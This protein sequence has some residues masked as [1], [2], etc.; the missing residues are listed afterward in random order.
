MVCVFQLGWSE[1]LANAARGD[2]YIHAYRTCT[3]VH[4]H[5]CREI[6]CVRE[7]ENVFE[8]EGQ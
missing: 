3:C 7:R 6:S 4:A 2:V 5:T 8:R 1:C